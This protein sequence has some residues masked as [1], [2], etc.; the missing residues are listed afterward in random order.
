MTAKFSRYTVYMVGRELHVHVT[1]YLIQV[2]HVGGEM[3]LLASVW[4]A[5][6]KWLHSSLGLTCIVP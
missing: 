5:C 3:A 4:L 2:I 1:G 6:Q